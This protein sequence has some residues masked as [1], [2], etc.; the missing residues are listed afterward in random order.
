M[1]THFSIVPFVLI[2]PLFELISL[3]KIYVTKTYTGVRTSGELIMFSIPFLIIAI[4]FL[5]LQY[6]RLN[7]RKIEIQYTEQQFQE[8]VKRTVQSLSWRIEKNKRNLLIAYRSS[9][10]T[11]SWGEMITIIRSENTLYVNSICDPNTISSVISYGWNRRNLKTFL[12][13]LIEVIRET[14]SSDC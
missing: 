9:N 3:F 13:H 12:N 4:A 11:G 2:V 8:A 5:I 1:L 6:Q 10:W 14:E 7:L